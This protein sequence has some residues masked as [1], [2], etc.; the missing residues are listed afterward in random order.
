[1]SKWLNGPTAEEDVVVSTRVRVARNM[2]KYKFPSYLSIAESDELT[3]D[4]LIN[5]KDALKDNYQFIRIRDLTMREQLVYI[6]EHLISPNMIQNSDKSS[7]LLRDDER[8]TIMIN[9]EDHIRIQTLFPGLNLKKAWELCSYIDD[10]LESKI[11][12]AYDEKWGYLTSCPTNVGTGLR[13]SVMLHLPCITMTGNVNGVIEGLRKIGLTA[14]GLYGEG[15]ETLGNLYQVSNQVTLGET[16]EDIIDKLNKVI[17]Q[18]VNRERSTREYL[19]EKRIIELEDKIY[20]SFGILSYSRIIN[21]KEA[22]RHLS[23]IRLGWEMGLLKSEKLKD[24]MKLMI[25]I[26]PA[27]IQKSLNKDMKE[28][29]RDI[30]RA[31]II[32]NFIQDLEG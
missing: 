15:S 21:S 11:D 9:E 27:N 18:I 22:M 12:Y 7:F 5:I 26:Q 13:A 23:N 31:Q 1:M 3:E 14:R 30:A 4:I 16:E 17:Y 25:E 20:R 6:E 10:Q 24:I 2:T 19:M 8:A 32:R 29:E 28:K